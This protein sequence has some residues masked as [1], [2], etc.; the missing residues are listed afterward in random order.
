[1]LDRV[2]RRPLASLLAASPLLSTHTKLPG[3]TDLP[4][5][6]P[7]IRS[8]D[9][10]IAAFPGAPTPADVVV[11]TP[12]V[13]MPAVAGAIE[14]ARR[15]AVAS[16]RFFEPALLL[17]SRDHTVADLRI[18]IAGNGDNAASLAALATLRNSVLPAALGSLPAVD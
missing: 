17:S 4:K 14:R 18:P 16:G 8:Y 13:R 7:I 15:A 2:L 10:V 3:Y 1:M 9:A 11:R 5:S 6:L 12:D